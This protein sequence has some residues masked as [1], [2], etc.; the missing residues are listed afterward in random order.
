MGVSVARIVSKKILDALDK[1]TIPWRRE[2]LTEKYNAVSGRSYTGVNLIL[3]PAVGGYLTVNQIKKLNAKIKKGSKPYLAVFWMKYYYRPETGERYTEKEIEKMQFES[4]YEKT[5]YLSGFLTAMV[6]RYYLVYHTSDIEN[7]PD[8]LIRKRTPLSDTPKERF[9]KMIDDITNYL[10][11]NGIGF[12][13]D[14]KTTRAYYSLTKDRIVLPPYK[15]FRSESS[16]LTALAHEVIH[17]T[18]HPKRLSRLKEV[19]EE[20]KRAFEELVAEIGA[21]MLCS[22]YGIKPDWENIASYV[23]SW[24]KIF[25]N[26]PMA[27]VKAANQSEK[28]VEFFRLYQKKTTTKT[29]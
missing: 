4:D 25:K 23:E 24:A 15:L 5:V 10:N 7:L 16:Y 1:G 26:K 13:H 6:L 9:S 21:S 8:N 28:A 19:Q 27:I 29:G 22:L 11:K 14:E 17:S 18:G 20:E 3:L 12:M 2:W